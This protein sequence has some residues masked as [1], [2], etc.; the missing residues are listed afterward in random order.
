MKGSTEVK[1][2][3]SSPSET[4]RT[5][6][7]E[8]PA[9][10]IE[11]EI[12]KETENVRKN[13]QLPGFRKGKAP[14]DMVRAQYRKKIEATAVENVIDE[15][16]KEAI[17][18]EK[19]N[20]FGQAGISNVKY[21]PGK[22]L[23]FTAVIEVKPEFS[24][25]GLEGIRVEREEQEVTN[26]MIEETLQKIQMRFGTV[27]KKNEAAEIGDQLLIDIEEV[28]ASTRV[29]L[30][31]KQYPDLK[32][33][34][35]EKIRGEDFEKQLIGAKAGDTILVT[36][37]LNQYFITD[38]KQQVQQNPTEAHHMVK[39]KEVNILELP[40]IDDELAN[41]MGYENVETLREGVRASLIAHLEDSAKEK[42]RDALERETVRIINPP[43]LQSMV[44]RYLDYLE[45]NVKKRSNKPVNS[46]VLREENKEA[47]TEKVQWYLIREKLIEQEGFEIT[48]REIDEYLEQYAKENNMDPKRVKIENRSEEKRSLIIDTLLDNKIFDYLEDKAV[49]S[50]FKKR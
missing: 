38:P 3:V 25:S 28:D 30:I 24:I 16:F 40:E 22:P 12:E 20:P 19:L 23:E 27:R 18:S 8:V 1:V 48:G 7:I 44:E 32:V 9:D 43:A 50:T 42:L 21:E 6:K 49:V 11:V 17:G 36:E 31:G 46:R 15:N 35:G 37:K 5:L 14:L 45:E 4:I 29:P 33:R 39:V 2:T 47:V 34:L 13:V 26:E 10:R 41:E